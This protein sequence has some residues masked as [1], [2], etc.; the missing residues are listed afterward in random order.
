I[1]ELVDRVLKENHIH[2]EALSAV[3]TIDLKKDEKGLLEF[4]RRRNLP[5]TV[6]TAEELKAVEGDFSASGFVSSITGVDNVCERAAVKKGGGKLIIKKTKGDS[7][8]CAVTLQDWR[9]KI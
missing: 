5:F 6:Y 7:S 2:P 1:E 9:I 3:A 4:C 8:T